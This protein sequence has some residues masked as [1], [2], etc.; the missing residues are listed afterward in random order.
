MIIRRLAKFDLARSFIIHNVLIKE[1]KKIDPG[2]LIVIS[3]YLM[4]R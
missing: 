2:F 3:E 4:S 1:L